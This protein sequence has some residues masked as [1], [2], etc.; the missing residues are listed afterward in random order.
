MKRVL[1]MML[2]FIWLV[3][4]VGAVPTF[5]SENT[6]LFRADFSSVA[7][8]AT[9]SKGSGDDQWSNVLTNADKKLYV[10][11]ATEDGNAVLVLGCEEDGQRGGPRVARNLSLAGLSKIFVSL[12]VKSEQ[13]NLDVLLLSDEGGKDYTTTLWSGTT[14]G[15]ATVELEVDLDKKTI[16]QTVNGE[17]AATLTLHAIRDFSTTS[18]RFTPTPEPGQCGEL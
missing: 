3:S 8:G 11:S 15:W 12:R 17:K 2:V 5:A 10:R 7:E 6:V 16:V 13:T 18:F 14:K 1:A 9:P 4:C